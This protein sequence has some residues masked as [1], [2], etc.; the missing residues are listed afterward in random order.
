MSNI[1]VMNKDMPRV[2][3]IVIRAKQLQS[4]RSFRAFPDRGLHVARANHKGAADGGRT[5]DAEDCP[6]PAASSIPAVRSISEGS[7]RR[8]ALLNH[9]DIDPIFTCNDGDAA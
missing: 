6:S 4:A 9:L 5:P 1:V 7:V 8:G 2:R 3:E